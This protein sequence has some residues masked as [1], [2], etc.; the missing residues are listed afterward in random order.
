MHR[1]YQSVNYLQYLSKNLTIY[2]YS[3]DRDMCFLGYISTL[4]TNSLLHVDKKK[5]KTREKEKE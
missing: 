5:T 1:D 3:K 4:Q 2:M